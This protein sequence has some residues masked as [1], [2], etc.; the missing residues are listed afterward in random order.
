MEQTRG[1]IF[2]NIMNFLKK[3]SNTEETSS[4]Q[5]ILRVYRNF[6]SVLTDGF[7][8]INSEGIGKLDQN[9]F[10]R[11]KKWKLYLEIENLTL[12]VSEFEVLGIETMSDFQVKPIEKE[13]QVRALMI[14][15]FKI[16][17]RST[18]NE[19]PMSQILEIVNLVQEDE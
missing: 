8:G 18:L 4:T 2:P 11:I 5:M 1:T 13:L 17:I 3:Y 7:F 12:I 9:T 6:S 10:I 15:A 16:Q 14:P 19:I